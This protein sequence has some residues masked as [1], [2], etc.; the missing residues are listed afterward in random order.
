MS[1]YVHPENQNMLWSAI[2]KSVLFQNLGTDK[3][4]W[5]RSVIQ[6]MHDRT[7]SVT[8]T[9]HLT[10]MNKDTVLVMLDVLKHNQSPQSNLQTTA[11][12]YVPPPNTP[13]YVPQSSTQSSTQS[14]SN[15]TQNQ[16][17]E[18]NR[19]YTHDYAAQQKQNEI[20]AH[21]KHLQSQYQ[22]ML[23]RD[24]P[25]QISFKEPALDEPITNMNE[26]IE[27]HRAERAIEMM[28]Y[29]P[30]AINNQTPLL[31]I[32]N[33]TTDTPIIENIV[34]FETD[35][36]PNTIKKSV[37]WEKEGVN[38]EELFAKW[39]VELLTDIRSEIKST[40]ESLMQNT[41]SNRQDRVQDR[42]QDKVQEYQ[43]RPQDKDPVDL[44]D[45]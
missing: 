34:V 16:M 30:P 26:L 39:K 15:P 40:I 31:K 14:Y 8:D 4:S 23:T 45:S 21:Y 20:D 41:A 35:D 10:K 37:H 27:K 28:K 25:A 22:T 44:F 1:L 33:Q 38:L 6:Q 3:E 18:P 13:V 19:T 32:D 11:P 43:D 29:A 2:S 7:P 9:E 42:V 5:F 12:V 24:T 36:T 17:L